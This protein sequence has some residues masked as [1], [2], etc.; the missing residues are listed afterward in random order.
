M[1]YLLNS[2]KV[3]EVGARIPSWYKENAIKNGFKGEWLYADIDQYGL[4]EN[5]NTF[6]RTNPVDIL[7]END[8]FHC[9]DNSFDVI[10]SASVLEHVKYIWKFFE[11]SSRILNK[12]GFFISISPISWPYHEAPIDCWRIHPDGMRALLEKVDLEEIFIASEC[13]E[14]KGKRLLPGTGRDC[15]GPRQKLRYD[16][17]RLIGNPVEASIDMVTIAKKN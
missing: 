2:K 8:I 13:L 7:I 11:E 5:I 3:L 16:I 9:P 17:F 10:Y 6:E 4:N 15:Q 1:E 14:F 12:N